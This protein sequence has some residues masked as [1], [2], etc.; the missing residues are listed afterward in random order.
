MGRGLDSAGAAQRRHRPGTRRPRSNPP[1][2]TPPA[3]PQVLLYHF[4]EIKR[5]E[6]FKKP[7]SQAEAGTFFGFESAFKGTGENGYPGGLFDPL[8]LANGP[9]DVSGL[10]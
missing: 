7:G 8:G 3:P 2:P 10:G 6:D 9:K 5:L 1:T 4:V